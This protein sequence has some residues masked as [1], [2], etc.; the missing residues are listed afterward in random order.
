MISM[1]TLWRKGGREKR[2]EYLENDRWREG[3][4]EG[5]K[6]VA[7]ILPVEQGGG[8]EGVP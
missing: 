3:G 1:A 2:D 8:R 6:G 7:A 5:G 4:R